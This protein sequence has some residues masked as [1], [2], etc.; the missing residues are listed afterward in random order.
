LGLSVPAA[1]DSAAGAGVAPFCFLGGLLLRTGAMAQA[2]AT[3]TT[4]DF[5]INS[6]AI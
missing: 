6:V 3:T 1:A 2:M 4:I 5:F